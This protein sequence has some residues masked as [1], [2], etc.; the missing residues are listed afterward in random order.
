MATQTVSPPG[1]TSLERGLA[2]ASHMAYL[3]LAV[4]AL[5]AWSS[6]DLIAPLALLAVSLGLYA[7]LCVWPSPFVREHARASV[8]YQLLGMGATLVL[9]FAAGWLAIFTWGLGLI[10]FILAA[11][12]AVGLWMMPTVTGMKRAL[13]GEEFHYRGLSELRGRWL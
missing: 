5:L 7:A 2:A 3:G 10:V 4:V 6:G 12:L 11:P 13:H 9:L 8:R 1:G